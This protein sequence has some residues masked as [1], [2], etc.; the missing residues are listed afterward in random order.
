MRI[1]QTRTV[2]IIGAGMAGTLLSIL[3]ARRGFEVELY[4][5]HGD[6]RGERQWGGQTVDLALGERAR[7]ALSMCGLLQQVDRL[8]TRV[9]GR[10]IHDRSGQ[11]RTV[12]Y[13]NS[14]EDTLYSIRRDRLRRCL[15]DAAESAGK[16]SIHFNHELEQ[17]DWTLNQAQFSA[18]NGLDNP[19]GRR[20]VSF[21]VLIGA[22]GPVSAV[23]RAMGVATEESLLDSGYKAFTIPPNDDGSFRMNQDGLHV[24]PRG[25]YMM[26]AFPDIEGSFSALL[27]LPRKGDHRMMWGFEELDSWVRQSAFMEANFPDAVPL[28]PRLEDDFR[29]CPVGLL[30]TVKCARWH[31]DGQALLIGDAAHCIVPFHGQGVNAAFEDCTSL[32]DL[33]DA[34]AEDWDTLFR[35]FQNSRKQNTDAL[36]DM[37]IDAY[38]TMRESARHRDFMLRKALERELERRHPDRFV[39]RYSLVMFHRIPYLEAF[40]RGKAQSAILDEMLPGKSTL[41]EMDFKQADRLIGDRLPVIANL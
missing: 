5:R 26:I 10:M 1:D 3:F 32:L 21:E 8:C 7:H 9:H 27:F 39:A 30:G 12:P 18:G 15:L 14:D 24:W 17:V 6:P 40:E 19:G 41:S 4:E 31:R 16:V 23:R 2:T 13:G 36:A 37:S 28:I 29:D 25:G 38:Q 33:L 11:V 20:T 35:R 34:G 22:D